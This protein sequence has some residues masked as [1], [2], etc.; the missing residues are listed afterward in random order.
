[1]GRD[2][3]ATKNAGCAASPYFHAGNSPLDRHLPELP[4]LAGLSQRE[5]SAWQR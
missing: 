5:K 3:L 2:K 1:M 4:R